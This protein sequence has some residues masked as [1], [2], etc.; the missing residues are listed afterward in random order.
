M[1]SWHPSPE[2]DFC[3]VSCFFSLSI[4]RKSNLKEKAGCVNASVHMEPVLYT[5]TGVKEGLGLIFW[6]VS[7]PKWNV[8]Q[9]WVEDGKYCINPS[10]SVSWRLNYAPFSAMGAFGSLF[11]LGW[12]WLAITRG[13]GMVWS[14]CWCFFFWHPKKHSTIEVK[15]LELLKKD[16]FV[17]SPF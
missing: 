3:L 10:S 1:W 11:P 17:L 2:K 9:P 6:S 7:M 15:N 4:N 14:G 12:L 16:F 5:T 8:Q 13:W